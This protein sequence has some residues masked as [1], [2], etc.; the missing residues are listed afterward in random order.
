MFPPPARAVLAFGCA[1]AWL[2]PAAASAQWRG[3]IGI[4]ERLY[5]SPGAGVGP[6]RHEPVI[7]AGAAGRTRLGAARLAFGAS[8]R[9]G[10][11][12]YGV[13]ADVHELSAGL[14]RGRWSLR[15]GVSQVSWGV[16]ESAQLVDVLNQRA[17]VPGVSGGLKLG[18][19]MVNLGVRGIWGTGTVDFYLLPWFRA[20]PFVGRAARVW[21]GQM[22]SADEPAFGPADGR[23][24]MDW[25]VR[26]TRGFGEWDVGLS[27]FRGTDREPAFQSLIGEEG[28]GRL[29]PRYDV[30]RRVG[31][32]IQWT[33]GRWLGKLEAASGNPSSGRYV[34]VGTG[35]EFA[36]ADYVSAFVEYVHDS[37]G[38]RAP[39]SLERDVCVGGRLLYR[40]GHVGLRGSVDRVT[41]NASVGFET[42]RRLSNSTAVTL[43]AMAFLGD[44]ASEPP[45]ALRHDSNVALGVHRY[46]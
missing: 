24:R 43:Q 28:F 33:H 25:A 29:L 36:P 40:D 21:S 34:A 22:V 1:L 14:T 31:V 3:D 7:V 4:T 6:A 17:M 11:E 46:F 19:P 20:R 12:D 10:D 5:A 42:A 32:D 45:V 44:A 16:L 23:H 18:Q 38:A 27:L 13:L 41:G 2:L 37:R 35:L 26:G 8:V 30:V 39:T 9:A 15:A